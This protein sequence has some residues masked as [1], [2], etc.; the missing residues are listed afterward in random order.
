MHAWHRIISNNVLTA[1]WDI[2]PCGLK[3][4]QTSYPSVSVIRIVFFH[5]LTSCIHRPP[6]L[7]QPTT[8]GGLALPEPPLTNSFNSTTNTKQAF[9]AA[10]HFQ[11]RCRTIVPFNL[12]SIYRRTPHPWAT[13]YHC[14]HPSE[15]CCNGEFRLLP[16]S[17]DHCTLRD[18]PRTQRAAKKVNRCLC[19]GNRDYALTSRFSNIWA[20]F[21]WGLG[22]TASGSLGS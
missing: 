4:L 14:T 20:L 22:P 8:N 5:W 3:N 12:R 9:I 2:P 18:V 21:Y 17:E 16:R 1:Q 10:C 19:C 6:S 11:C 15:D 7:S 13:T